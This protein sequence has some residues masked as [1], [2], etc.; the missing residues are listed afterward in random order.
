MHA[1]HGGPSPYKRQCYDGLG[2]QP[3]CKGELQ[4]RCTPIHDRLGKRISP[5]EQLEEGSNPCVSDE[6]CARDPE[7]QED[8]Q[9]DSDTIRNQ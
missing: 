7:V 4:R 5:Q 6:P 9:Y 8:H 1:P 3:I 2:Q